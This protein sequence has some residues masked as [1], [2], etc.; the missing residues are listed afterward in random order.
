MFCVIVYQQNT[1]TFIQSLQDIKNI[2]DDAADAGALSADE[3]FNID[4]QLAKE[5]SLEYLG[6]QCE[7]I[8]KELND[9][10]LICNTTS[11]SSEYGITLVYRP[12]SVTASSVYEWVIQK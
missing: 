11:I 8:D 12:Y 1:A 7:S 10:E 6:L 4:P 2:A 9:F 5:R 3:K